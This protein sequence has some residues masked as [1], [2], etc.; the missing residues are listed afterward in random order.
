MA[1]VTQESMPPE[2]RQTA[3]DE[4]GRMKDELS[5]TSASF[6]IV[7]LLP[8]MIGNQLVIKRLHDFGVFLSSLILPPSSLLSHPAR[9]RA[10]DVLV[11]LQLHAKFHSASGDPI[12]QFSQ[13][14]LAPG[15]RDQDRSGAPFEIVL[16]DHLE[17]EVPVGAISDHELHFVSIGLQQ[18]KIG[19]MISFSLA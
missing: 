14:N 1:A 10:P 7:S 3:K 4:G 18:I 13:V 15:R 2:T 6:K 17:R 12:R 19:P 16:S 9:V 5:S 11:Q 8:P